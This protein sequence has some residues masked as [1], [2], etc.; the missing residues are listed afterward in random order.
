MGQKKSTRLWELLDSWKEK[1][2]TDYFHNST[3]PELSPIAVV[4]GGR[5][6]SLHFPYWC[7]WTISGG[8]GTLQNVRVR[9][10]L[11]I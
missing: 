2:V 5:M 3:L 9:V 6:W 11:V 1:P 7:R 4:L 8:S 10:G